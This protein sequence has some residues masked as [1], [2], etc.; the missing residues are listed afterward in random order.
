MC[1][2]DAYNLLS[3][4]PEIDRILPSRLRGGSLKIEAFEDVEVNSG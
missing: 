4:Y 2:S 1:A 3:N